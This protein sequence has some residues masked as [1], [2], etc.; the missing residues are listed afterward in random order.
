MVRRWVA[1][2]VALISE[3]GCETDGVDVLISASQ[4]YDSEL[5]SGCDG[6]CE[7]MSGK[8]TDVASEVWVPGRY[9]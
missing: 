1:S 4:G 6:V 8:D 3:V 9:G 7:A 2:R 5:L